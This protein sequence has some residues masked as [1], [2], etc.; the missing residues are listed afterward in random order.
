M[1]DSMMDLADLDALLAQADAQ[2]AQLQSDYKHMKKKSDKVASSSSSSS[3]AGSGGRHR[4]HTKQHAREGS[5]AQLKGAKNAKESLRP[6]GTVAKGAAAKKRH[7]V[8]DSTTPPRAVVSPRVRKAA[9]ASSARTGSPRATGRLGKRA[10]ARAAESK[11]GASSAVNR[12]LASL[13]LN[14]QKKAA[15]TSSSGVSPAQRFVEKVTKSP[16]RAAA[17][18]LGG[19]S[20]HSSSRDSGGAKSASLTRAMKR[21]EALELAKHRRAPSNS[22]VEDRKVLHTAPA[23]LRTEKLPSIFSRP[24]LNLNSGNARAVVRRPKESALVRKLPSLQ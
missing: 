2:T 23:K 24:K 21:A 9:E 3:S 11:H 14:T 10:A 22:S 18:P 13:R 8:N 20:K 19:E 15:G 4:H 7:L 1:P 5:R 6:R 12:P 17:R 16:F